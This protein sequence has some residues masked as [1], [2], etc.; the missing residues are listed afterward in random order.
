MSTVDNHLPAINKSGTTGSTSNKVNHILSPGKTS[1]EVQIFEGHKFFWKQ[2]L[3]VD[4]NF[5]Y[6]S[7]AGYYEIIPYDSDACVELKRIYLS[8]E[9]LKEAVKNDLMEKIAE[10][11]KDLSRDRFKKMPPEEELIAK[12]TRN[13]IRDFINNR[14][15]AFVENDVKGVKLNKLSV[16]TIDFDKLH[17]VV[18]EPSDPDSATPPQTDAS[19]APTGGDPATMAVPPEATS[20]TTPKQTQIRRRRKTTSGDFENALKD[21]RMNSRELDKACNQAARLT[22][23]SRKSVDAFKDALAGNLVG[24][25]K[26]VFDKSTPLGMF[27]W[28]ARR[29]ILQNTVEKVRAELESRDKKGGAIKVNATFPSPDGELMVNPAVQK[30]QMERAPH[31]AALAEN[32]SR[33]GSPVSSPRDMEGLSSNRALTG[34]RGKAAGSSPAAGATNG[35]VLKHATSAPVHLPDVNSKPGSAST[36]KKSTPKK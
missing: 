29:I 11:K 20:K 21:L 23:L 24:S 13:L 28:A 9:L 31:L 3:N 33:E 14:L 36:P 22:A 5:I 15:V 30:A 16:D 18:E 26:E 34:S 17:V 1:T 12:A 10:I 4:L 8:E 2:R 25:N 35:K 32:F 27:K 19:E 6:H 7:D